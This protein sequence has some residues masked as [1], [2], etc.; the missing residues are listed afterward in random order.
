VIVR[1]GNAPCRHEAG[2]PHDLGPAAP[3][4]LRGF[5]H[6]PHGIP[7]GSF[8]RPLP[9]TPDGREVRPELRAKWREDKRRARA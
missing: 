7:G 5:S 6:R 3:A 9:S 1:N 2:C 4:P 8:C